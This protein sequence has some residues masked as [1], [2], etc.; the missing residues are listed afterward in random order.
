VAK[1]LL[2]FNPTRLY[3]IIGGG[4]STKIQQQVERQLPPGFF[5]PAKNPMR[6]VHPR[7]DRE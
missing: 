7:P 2:A 3:N 4:F 5:T 1:D 6:L